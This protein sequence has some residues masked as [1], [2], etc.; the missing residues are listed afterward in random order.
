MS[1]FDLNGLLIRAVPLLHYLGTRFDPKNL[2]KSRQ[3]KHLMSLKF[4]L[5]FAF[6]IIAVVET[7]SGAWVNIMSNRRWE[8]LWIS[9]EM[10][11][12][13]QSSWA[14]NKGKN[15]D[16]L[17]V[18][19]DWKVCSRNL[20]AH[21]LTADS[22]EQAN[23]DILAKTVLK[24]ASTVSGN[25]VNISF[26]PLMPSCCIDEFTWLRC[27]SS[28]CNQMLVIW[29]LCEEVYKLT[30]NVCFLPVKG[31][32]L[33]S[34]GRKFSD[35]TIFFVLKLVLVTF[36]PLGKNCVLLLITFAFDESFNLI[37]FFSFLN[38]FLCL[39]LFVIFITNITT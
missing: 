20:S 4:S 3:R 32:P 2:V 6:T 30:L 31:N 24:L 8:S 21:F 10:W 37:L 15:G 11:F 7:S 28:S 18:L 17:S 5:N 29:F 34:S 26:I 27:D 25:L 22:W 12:M 9:R 38:S 13:A 39:V 1:A 35:R 14:F 33:V 16:M 19:I 36:N 23:S